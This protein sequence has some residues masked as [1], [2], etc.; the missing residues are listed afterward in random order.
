LDKKADR[1][2][3]TKENPRTQPNIWRTSIIYKSGA[4]FWD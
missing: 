4:E 1:Y 2:S 3:Y